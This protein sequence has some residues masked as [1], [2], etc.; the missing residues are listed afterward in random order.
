MRTATDR[1]SRRSRLRAGAIVAFAIGALTL[2]VGPLATTSPAAAAT[3][4]VELSSDGTNF[5]TVYSG[6]LFPS[7]ALMVPQ[8]AASAMFWVKNTSTEPAFLRVSIANVV[9][10]ANA[11]SAALSIGATTSSTSGPQVAVDAAQPC[12]VLTEGRI[13]PAG[14]IAWVTTSLRLADLGGTS[15]QNTDVRFDIQVGL[16][17][18]ATGSMP[19]TTCLSNSGTVPAT[20]GPAPTGG[21]GGTGGGSGTSHGTG[22]G[23]GSPAAAS[24]DAAGTLDLPGI[25]H[26]SAFAGEEVSLG[27]LGPNTDRFFQEWF[28]LLWLIGAV[29]G[30]GIQV[31]VARRRAYNDVDEEVAEW[32]VDGQ[33]SGRRAWSTTSVSV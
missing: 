33:R 19:S 2:L 13:V 20:G 24:G 3:P 8:S 21:T 26:G 14:G 31:L 25:P 17:S 29:A 12:Y 16:S 7:T 10:G 6:T 27:I 28:V 22:T 4:V 9:N 18:T 15:G 23:H 5:S 11:F 32:L 30:G 1:T